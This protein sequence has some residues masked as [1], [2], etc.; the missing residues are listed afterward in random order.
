MITI[1]LNYFVVAFLGLIFGIGLFTLGVGLR[2]WGRALIK[3][4]TS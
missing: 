4:I 3:W 1:E 2:I